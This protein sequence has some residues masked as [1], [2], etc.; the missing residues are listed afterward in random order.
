MKK[1]GFVDYYIS[2]WHANNYPTWIREACE[3]AGLS[4]EVAYAWAEKDESPYDGRSTD[5]WCRDFGVEKCAGI[6][7]LC[8]K[9][10]VIIVLAPSDPE[11]H[12]AYTSEV[13]RYGKLTYVDKT[14]APDLKTA[15]AMFEIAEKYGTH[16]FTT[17][18]LRYA[19][20]LEKIDTGAGV[21]TT[22]GG[23]NLPEYIIH[24]VEMLVKLMGKAE[25]VKAQ[26]VDGSLVF[27]L[28]YPDSR[29]SEMTYAPELS[30]TVA[31][32]GS[33]ERTNISS[34]FFV[35]LI[36]DV[37]R[38]FES[39]VTSFE[40]EE[41][42]EVMRLREAALVASAKMGEWISLDSI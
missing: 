27:T 2:E 18:A 17:S 5:E 41:T 1:I 8:E 10:D 4:Y 39:G 24:Q 11:K 26:K 42:L 21:S 38:F 19:Q 3:K 36:G 28:T 7:E 29:M 32:L 33:A 40:G 9:S 20:E 35:G 37:L 25:K 23:S 30:Y 6:A 16:F 34:P 22:G 13:F 14:F 15:E 12:L 31:S